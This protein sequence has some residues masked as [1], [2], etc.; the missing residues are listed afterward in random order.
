[1]NQRHARH[2]TTLLL[3][4]F[5]STAAAQERVYTLGA[6]A[7]HA[8]DFGRAVADAGDVDLDGVPDVAVGAPFDAGN[9]PGSGRVF[10]YSGRTGDLLWERGGEHDDDHFGWSL[11]GVGD[12]DGD[13]RSDVIVGAPGWDNDDQWAARTGRIYLLAGADGVSFTALSLSGGSLGAQVG[14]DVCGL[15]DINGDGVGD[16]AASAP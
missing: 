7:T 12:L 6:E 4:L 5:A 16:Y 2:T 14:Y 10:V 3:A 11:D 8:S 13:G 15:G 1:M 9:G